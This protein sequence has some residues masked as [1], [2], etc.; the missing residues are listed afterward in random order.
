[1]QWCAYLYRSLK[2]MIAYLFY[3][4]ACE[5]SVLKIAAQRS[6]G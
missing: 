6:A 5:S 1:M 4:E 2:S 3:P